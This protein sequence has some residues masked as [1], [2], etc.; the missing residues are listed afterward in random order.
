MS[1]K[2]ISAAVLIQA[3]GMLLA[4]E[5]AIDRTEDKALYVMWADTM[6]ARCA[7]GFALGNAL[8]PITI[9]TESKECPSPSQS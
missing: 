3:H 6:R 1:S 5:K 7:L 4:L 8:P 9:T 2:T